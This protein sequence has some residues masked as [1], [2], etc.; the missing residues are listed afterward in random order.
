VR[1]TAITPFV[2]R[3]KKRLDRPPRSGVGSPRWDLTY[4]FASSRSSGVNGAN[5]NFAASSRLHFLAHRDSVGI[6]MEPHEPQ[7][8]YI[9]ETAEV[10]PIHY[11]YNSELIIFV[12]MHGSTPAGC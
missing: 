11:L 6:V 4:P 1:F 8:D 10:I 5:R 3:R 7:N 2:V 9:F 12:N